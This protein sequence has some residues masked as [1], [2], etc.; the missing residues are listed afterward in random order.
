M[1]NLIKAGIIAFAFSLMFI[2]ADSVN[3]QNRQRN[4]EAR[5][6]YREDMRDARQDFRKD[7]RSG[8]TYREARRDFREERRDAR[9]DY[10]S[11]TGRRINRGYYVSRSRRAYPQRS[12]IYYR[13]GRRY[14]RS[15]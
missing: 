14:V 6:E 3:A 13:N 15:Y 11:D 12:T 10:R 1:K 8:K 9:R 4:R 2:G 7:I 5:R